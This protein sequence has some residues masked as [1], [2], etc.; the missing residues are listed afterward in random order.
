M[1]TEC[2]YLNG[3]VQ[4]RSHREKIL[5][6]NPKDI[7]GNAEKEEEE[8][9]DKFFETVLHYLDIDIMQMSALTCGSNFQQ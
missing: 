8:G 5:M 2:D 7:A 3:W 1:K 4:R 9:G 6:V